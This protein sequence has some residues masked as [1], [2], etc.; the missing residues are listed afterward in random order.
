MSITRV[1]KY[2]TEDGREF[3][4][5]HDARGHELVLRLRGALQSILPK[6]STNTYDLTTVAAA[7]LESEFR[8]EY[9]KVMRCQGTLE[10]A[11][12]AKE[13]TH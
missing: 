10:R 8:K 1:V 6:Q 7:L 2:R 13:T 12:S 4:N 3:T 9:S 5:E 11:M